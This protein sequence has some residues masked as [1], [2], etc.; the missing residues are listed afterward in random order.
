MSTRAVIGWYVPG[1]SGVLSPYH[2]RRG[3]RCV[4]HRFDGYPSILGKFLWRGYRE[5]NKTL[6]EYLDVI[7]SHTAGWSSLQYG[8]CYCHPKGD[9]PPEKGTGILGRVAATRVRARY[10]YLFDR[11]SYTMDVVP[12]GYVESRSERFFDWGARREI[13]LLDGEEPDWD[14]MQAYMDSRE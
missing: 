12:L 2:S 7:L 3:M 4:Y 14:T 13:H 8:E 5:G 11:Q 9:R 10:A 6:A 1:P